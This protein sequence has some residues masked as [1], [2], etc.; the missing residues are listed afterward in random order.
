G[1]GRQVGLLAGPGRLP[2]ARVPDQAAGGGR[3]V[4][5]EQLV[6]ADDLA[7]RVP[8]HVVVPLALSD[9][10]VLAVPV[11]LR[12]V[13]AVL[14]HGVLAA[15]GRA[16]RGRGAARARIAAGWLAAGQFGDADLL[17]V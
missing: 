9:P 11:H 16:G 10:E 14:P 6:D 12:D 2:I 1:P 3:A 17:A 7:V 5:V 4:P 15:G 13:V 8:E